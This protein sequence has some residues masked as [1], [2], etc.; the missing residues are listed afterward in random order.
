LGNV[1]RELQ[2][3][4]VRQLTAGLN[5]IH[6]SELSVIH[7]FYNYSMAKT[8]ADNKKLLKD[9]KAQLKVL[10]EKLVEVNKLE[11]KDAYIEVKI[12]KNQARFEKIKQ[13]GVADRAVGKFYIEIDILSKEGAVFVPISIASGK[14]T[15]GFMYQIEG[16]AEGLLATAEIKVRGEGVTQVTVGTLHFAKIPFGK[17]ASFEIRATIKGESGKSYK[18]V[19]TRL[20]YKLN[21]S[22]IRYQQYLKE[23]HGESVKIS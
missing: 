22:D 1:W 6:L 7:L 9:L 2:T 8:P 10:Q 23:I 17:T 4:T 14:K 19:F 20:N 18:V 15:A 16:T 12:K 5:V 13:K 21:L 3:R 11:G